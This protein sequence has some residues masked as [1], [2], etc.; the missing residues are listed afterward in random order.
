MVTARSLKKFI[1]AGGYN[2]CKKQPDGTYIGVAEAARKTELGEMTVRRIMRE[3][4]TNPIPTAKIFF[5][6]EAD[7]QAFRALESEISRAEKLAEATKR[8]LDEC[9]VVNMQSVRAKYQLQG[10]SDEEAFRSELHNAGSLNAQWRGMFN[11][12]EKQLAFIHSE[13]E[14]IRPKEH[15]W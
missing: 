15:A 6:N 5:L 3:H 13:I 12:I 4:P 11:E 10:L 8:F 2:I 14:K 9:L 7:C 1:E